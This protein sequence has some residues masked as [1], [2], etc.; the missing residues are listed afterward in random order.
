MASRAL[1]RTPDDS[2]P[3]ELAPADLGGGPGVAHSGL[4]L[5]AILATVRRRLWVIL[6]IMA[7]AVAAAVLLTLLD[8]PRYTAASSVQINDQ[9]D[10]VIGS[11]SEALANQAGW[12]IDRFL[13]TQLDVLKSRGLA[14]RVVQKLKLQSDPAFYRA[15]ELAPPPAG[16]PADATRESTIGLLK[17]NLSVDLPAT[18]RIAQ[19]AFNSADPVM[20][21]RIAN[22][23]AE[24]FIQANLQRRYDSSAY[25][26]DFVR[27][28]LAE[29]KDRLE[30]SERALNAYAR[31]A[32][33]IRTGDAAAG[34][35]EKSSAGG[36]SVTTA[37]LL[38][39]NEAANAARAARITAAGRWESISRI[40]PL[41]SKEVL[42]NATVQAL[43]GTRAQTETKLREERAAHLDDHP[44][45]VALRAELAGLDDQIK[46]AANNVRAS[47]R[48]EYDAALSSEQA[49]AAQVSSLKGDTLAEQDRSV[50]YN[51]LAREADTNRTLYDGLLQRYKEL[52]AAA[53]I[54]AS[55]ISIIDRAEPP[56]SPSGPNL[57]TNILLAL[58]IG[59]ILSGMVVFASLQFDDGVRV[60]EDVERKLQLPLLG[61]V[62]QVA[63]DLNE[64]MADPKSAVSEAYNALRGSL[65]HSTAGGLPPVLLVTSAQASEGKTTTSRAIATALA[66][67]NKRVLLVDAD[68][69]R[70]SVHNMVGGSNDRGLSSLLTSQD[71]LASAVVPSG[72]PGLS[73]LT[74]G[75]IPPS[76]TEL[77]SSMRFRG[78]IDEMA[79][80]YDAVILD[81]PP[82]LGLA[83]SPSMS[84]LVDGVVLVVES[85]QSRRGTLRSALNRLRAMR[86][87]LLGVVLTKFDTSSGANRYSAYYG[88]DHYEYRSDPV[89]A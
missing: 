86:P 76:P 79:D 45:V 29:T 71:P 26:R 47:I 35:G 3:A 88:S 42:D 1:V 36:G 59:A 6:A 43:V 9:S 15:M 63:G 32:G 73:L 83:D 30:S 61:V 64:A 8:T 66:R 22:A 57:A 48:S 18:S 11:A 12:D 4:D 52:N 81:S 5:S 38:Q 39:L 89:R 33:L 56:M 27:G 77:I 46:A 23:F 41:R 28:Q 82:I 62:P 14:L 10:Q 37:S 50:R 13:N 68:L 19:I 65:L 20:S 31:A 2:W 72:E 21:A 75:P 16:M 67:I 49:L 44:S 69:R 17:G 85:G 84:P 60:P 55:N 58:L 78:L 80:A 40:P 25:A 53:G 70:P 34:S 54:S 74:S 87:I 51:I 24:E 7:A